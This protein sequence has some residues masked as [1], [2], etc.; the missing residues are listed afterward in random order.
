MLLAKSI[1]RYETLL[2]FLGDE[3]YEGHVTVQE[4][5]DWME[6]TTSRLES[7]EAEI[8]SLQGNEEKMREEALNLVKK[9]EGYE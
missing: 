7:F 8:K 3:Q 9:L 1:Q 6:S 2:K 5:V 4:L